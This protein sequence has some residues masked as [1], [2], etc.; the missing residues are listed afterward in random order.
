VERRRKEGKKENGGKE[1]KYVDYMTQK[2]QDSITEIQ[3][4]ENDLLVLL[5]ASGKL[6]AYSCSKRSVL[7]STSLSSDDNE[8]RSF[9][10][11]VASSSSSKAYYS[12]RMSSRCIRAIHL[13][14]ATERLSMLIGSNRWI[15]ALASGL[16]MCT[17]PKDVAQAQ[18]LLQSF[19]HNNIL[20]GSSNNTVSNTIA[21]RVAAHFSQRCA[22]AMSLLEMTALHC[23]ETDKKISNEDDKASPAFASAVTRLLWHQRLSSP[24]AALLDF[25]FRFSP[26]L[27][28]LEMALMRCD[29]TQKAAETALPTLMAGPVISSLLHVATRVM[30]PPQ[31]GAAVTALLKNAKIMDSTTTTTFNVDGVRMLLL[32]VKCC[33]CGTQF[34]YDD[35]NLNSMDEHHARITV[36]AALF[37]EKSYLTL[38]RL[39]SL[40]ASMMLYALEKFV[41]CSR[42]RK[43]K[44]A[45]GGDDDDSDGGDGSSSDTNQVVGVLL[46]IASDT[47]GIVFDHVCVFFAKIAKKYVYFILFLFFFFFDLHTNVYANRYEIRPL[48]P[49]DILIGVLSAF[50]ARAVH[51]GRHKSKVVTRGRR[52]SL[53]LEPDE[54]ESEV[55]R[56]ISSFESSVK[57]WGR[58]SHERLHRAV[59]EMAS[60][61]LSWPAAGLAAKFGTTREVLHAF[62]S[63]PSKTNTTENGMSR[64]AFVYLNEQIK[65]CESFENAKILY[66]SVMEWLPQLVRIDAPATADLIREI[67]HVQGSTRQPVLPTAFLQLLAQSK[68]LRRDMIIMIRSFDFV[69]ESED[70]C[71]SLCSKYHVPEVEAELYWRKG[72]FESADQTLIHEFEKALKRMFDETFEEAK[73]CADAVL[74]LTKL[75]VER[76]CE[77]SKTV[78]R[79]ENLWCALL[80]CNLAQLSVRDHESRVAMALRSLAETLLSECRNSMPLPSLLNRVLSSSSVS[81]LPLAE[82]RELICGVLRSLFIEQ[83]LL[84][85]VRRSADA[86]C[87]KGRL[88]TLPSETSCVQGQRITDTSSCRASNSSWERTAD[89]LDGLFFRVNR[90]RLPNRMSQLQFV[91]PASRVVDRNGPRKGPIPIKPIRVVRAKFPS[92]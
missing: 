80:Q 71:V 53:D 1:T 49:P 52:M 54:L 17:G 41:E 20:A 77:A 40:E 12:E 51:V 78:T 4:L 55:L 35:R 43:K 16:E 7:I 28:R 42:N 37:Q 14:T 81:R 69:I 19:L 5:T 31:Y 60:A 39:L 13:R 83:Q 48:L 72:D 32:Y 33:L 87:V 86:S 89:E 79:A 65:K 9:I 58:P 10:D 3:W 66:E 74:L 26:S 88:F 24:S 46:E 25:L 45:D 91:P 6:H 18:G 67:T 76:Y 36:C 34:P 62:L 29:W 56:L 30:N 23:V 47:T 8:K 64:A 2:F 38:R 44:R 90:N 61:G 50:T 27:N 15:P 84:R 85:S 63:Q 57:R 11:Y 70:S 59:V 21:A 82:M 22:D 73:E 68:N 92:F 75:F